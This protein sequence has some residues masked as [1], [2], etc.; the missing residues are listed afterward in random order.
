[1]WYFLIAAAAL[2]EV[3]AAET[4]FE[5][6]ILPRVPPM[7]PKQALES[8]EVSDGFR[9]ELVAAE[10]LVADPVAMAFD[11]SGRLYVVEMCDYSEQDQERLGK[12]RVLTDDDG[13]G[14]FDRSGVFIDRL[15]WPTAIACYNGGVFIG[16][17][18]NIL[19]CKDTDGDGACDEQQV[20]FTGFGR[21]NVQG[22]VNSFHWGLDHRIHGATS[23]VG[24]EITRP[25]AGAPPVVLRGRDFAFDPRTLTMEATTGG[26]Q[27]G[28]SFNRWGDRFVCSNSDHLQAIVFE[29]RYLARNPYQ[30][31][32]SARRSI[33]ADGPQATVYRLSP[34]EAWRI[35][36]TKLRVAGLV[37]GPIEGGGTPAGY[38]TSA[39]GVTIY[40]GGLWGQD[41]GEWAI[42]A[43]V[44][45]NL[46]H[47][48]RLNPDGVTY[49]GERVDEA[50]EFVRS[51]DIWF[52]PVQ[53]AIGPEGALY[54]ADMYREVIEHP[55]SLPAELKQQLDLT[56]GRDR[57]RIYRIVPVNFRQAKPAPLVGVST[58]DLVRLLDNANGW[59]RLTAL[60]L[61]YERQ[62]VAAAPAL[63]DQYSKCRHPES[64]IAVL[65]A[66]DGGQAL[67]AADI[68]RA[69]ADPHPQVRRH[70]VQLA[71]PMLNSSSVV[72]DQV[73]ALVDDRNPVVQ[74]QLALSLGECGDPRVAACLAEILVH[75]SA[76]EDI[77]AAALTSVRECA[78]AV[79]K[80]LLAQRKWAASRRARPVLSALVFQ[81]VKQGRE[82][83]LS[84]LLDAFAPSKAALPSE[85]VAALLQ[86][87]SRVPMDA[88]LVANTPQQ[89]ELH[90]WRRAA[91]ER[92]VQDAR[93]VLETA[94]ATL[95]QRLT[96]IE[97]L[98]FDR[99]DRQRDMLEPLLSPQ[100]PA[101]IHAAVLTALAA[102]D[103]PQ[104]AEMVLAHWDEW[105]PNERVQVTQLLLRRKPWA[106]ALLQHI[107]AAGAPTSALDPSHW[108][109][110]MNYPADDVS[111]LARKLHGQNIS[112][113]RRQVFQDY[114][115]VLEMVGDP[116]AGKIVFEKQCASCHELDGTGAAVG[117][118]LAAMASRGRESLLFNVLVP[119]GEVDAKNHEYVLLTADGQFV[120]GL[121]AGETSTAVTLRGADNK[122][123]TLLRVDIE[124]MRDTGKS[125]MPEGFEKLID[126][127]AMADLLTYLEQAAAK[128]TSR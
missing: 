73:F 32:A 14:R 99:F 121:I 54:V 34:V 103:S 70:A 50:T 42:V 94:D 76:S 39:T 101:A 124:E 78:G 80:E 25:G 81:V 12:V 8:F 89:A 10:P 9:M 96:A 7:S 47:R 5:V 127:R 102:Y 114:R 123:T 71:E 84:V 59:R 43:D 24:G 126:Q 74:F 68:V 23:S 90:E 21:S 109:Q 118:N 113:D 27:H 67:T 98:A 79:L 33:A 29:E 28:M 57:G 64:R 30:S 53:F 4:K 62:D 92:L 65:H 58:V 56:S 31:V 2:A 77:V 117:P 97:K 119:N 122:T 61:L 108:A 19:F 63:R 52:R 82:A 3:A 38:F 15:S 110:L 36:R 88:H 6:D 75:N 85:V 69:L 1:V 86:A 26:G 17:A 87:V 13:D 105:T 91:A 46:I 35:A 18:P 116:V 112:S 83:D 55:A 11:E 128:G 45:S 37:P 104:V 115:E 20:V 51:R 66:L 111:T 107:S 106:L 100:E 125:L 16:A 41:A 72:R 60:R 95:D 93:R 49:R 22:L 48:K 40:Q 120:T 44:G